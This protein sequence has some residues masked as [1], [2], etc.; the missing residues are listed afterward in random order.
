MGTAVPECRLHYN[1]HLALTSVHTTCSHQRG[2][3]LLISN[4]PPLWDLHQSSR[5]H[6]KQNKAF[7]EN[8]ALTTML[9]M[10]QKRLSV[11]SVLAY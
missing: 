2:Y 9:W 1:M 3:I 10:L 7:S 5:C 11:L 8:N 4:I 6:H